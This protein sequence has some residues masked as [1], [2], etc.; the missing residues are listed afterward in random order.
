LGGG[1]GLAKLIPQAKQLGGDGCTLAKL[2]PILKRLGLGGG[3]LGGQGS[4]S[5]TANADLGMN[6]MIVMAALIGAQ[7]ASGAKPGSSPDSTSQATGETT[8]E[9]PGNYFC[10]DV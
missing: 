4:G 5:S 8:S 2:V 9:G 10:N 1:G 6:G 7:M 3:N